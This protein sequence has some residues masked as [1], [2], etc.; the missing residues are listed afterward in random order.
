M[1]GDL[2]QVVIV[3]VFEQARHQR[4]VAA[5]FAKPDQLVV[6]I[7]GRLARDARQIALVA[8][9]A[10]LAVAGGAG[11]HAFGQGVGR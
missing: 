2:P 4:V 3:Q 1:A 11:T 6:Q 10:F 5:S 7:A 9:T 8:G